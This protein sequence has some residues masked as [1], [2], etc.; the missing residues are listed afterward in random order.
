MHGNP[1]RTRSTIPDAPSARNIGYL[2][3]PPPRRLVGYTLRHP[4]H[5]DPFGFDSVLGLFPGVGDGISALMGLYILS[6]AR[7]L[8]ASPLLL[9]RMGGNIALDT[10]L[11]SVPLL[12]DIFDVAF[13]SNTK[14]VRLLLAHLEKQGR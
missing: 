4:R 11:G 7:D 14:N 8:G 3:H 13:R 2:R 5:D 10:I 9:A 6:R 1:H 12:G